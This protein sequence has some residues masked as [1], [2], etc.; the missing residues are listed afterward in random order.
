MKSTLEIVPLLKG[1]VL[2]VMS[3]QKLQVR[4]LKMYTAIMGY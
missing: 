2:Y 1:R 3:I 4:T